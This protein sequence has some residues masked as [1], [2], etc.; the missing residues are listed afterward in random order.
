[1]SVATT[2]YRVNWG[3]LIASELENGVGI[4]GIDL[5]TNA[6]TRSWIHK[7]PY[8]T[9][10]TVNVFHT[11]AFG[12]INYK[13]GLAAY[14][15]PYLF[16]GKIG[17]KPGGTFFT[18]TTYLSSLIQDI[19]V[20]L[21][22]PAILYHD[23]S[24]PWTPVTTNASVIYPP[25]PEQYLTI[26]ALESLA[27]YGSLKFALKLSG[28]PAGGDPFTYYIGLTKESSN[29]TVVE[30]NEATNYD[31]E[32]PDWSA[33]VEGGCKESIDDNL[34]SHTDPGYHNFIYWTFK[35]PTY[36]M[37]T[38]AGLLA[39]GENCDISLIAYMGSITSY[40]LTG[41]EYDVHAYSSTVTASQ[42]VT[43]PA[44]VVPIIMENKD[45][46]NPDTYTNDDP[47]GWVGNY[48]TGTN[49]TTITIHVGT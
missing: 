39:D 24:S 1:M 14:N 32:S 47:W 33:A 31:S 27:N 2:T 20:G 11:D 23:G 17:A 12:N 15:L 25:F 45:T 7:T 35:V 9:L 26:S 43:K 44:N 8:I 13:T 49:D 21:Y 36:S 34:P 16:L 6:N 19:R 30:T 18:S 22:D 28:T 29:S 48:N 46:A 42:T 4:F 10:N 41:N 3:N 40:A 38:I 5:S 37:G